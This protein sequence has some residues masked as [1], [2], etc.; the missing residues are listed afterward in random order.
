[1]IKQRRYKKVVI[2]R[3]DEVVCGGGGEGIVYTARGYSKNF[4]IMMTL[5]YE[6]PA[7]SFSI[8]IYP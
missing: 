1:M 8:K 7:L 6:V 2:G 4:A 3:F 5:E